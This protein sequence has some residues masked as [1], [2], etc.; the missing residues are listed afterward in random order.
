MQEKELSFEQLFSQ[1]DAFLRKV[2][3]T[4]S[5]YDI[6]HSE[7]P[8]T[9]SFQSDLEKLPIDIQIMGPKNVK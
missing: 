6:T 3:V 1:Y 7:L 4:F 5:D 2:K 9:I 8:D